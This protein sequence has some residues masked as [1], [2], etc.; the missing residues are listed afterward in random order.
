VCEVQDARADINIGVNSGAWRIF[1]V[2]WES[3][4]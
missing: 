2:S 1:I 4:K 3:F